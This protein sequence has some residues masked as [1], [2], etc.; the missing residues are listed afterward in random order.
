MSNHTIYHGIN[1]VLSPVSFLSDE[2]L[3]NLKFIS[4]ATCYVFGK[5][6]N[7]QDMV[8]IYKASGVLKYSSLYSHAQCS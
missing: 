8:Q 5:L 3:A 6:S 2:K 1:T 4:T 7:I